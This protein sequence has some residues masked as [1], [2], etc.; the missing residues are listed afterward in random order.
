[1]GWPP[2]C[3]DGV[4]QRAPCG[5]SG[6]QAPSLESMELYIESSQAEFDSHLTPLQHARTF[7]TRI[8]DNSILSSAAGSRQL[9]TYLA[10]GAA[11]RGA[12]PTLAGA[13]GGRW[14]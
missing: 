14:R 6:H 1:M 12:L 3:G 8:S 4:C 5:A 2:I 10:G 11:G 7:T 9:P 13:S